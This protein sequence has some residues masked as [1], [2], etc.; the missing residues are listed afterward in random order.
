MFGALATSIVNDIWAEPFGALPGCA[1]G[2]S[3]RSR[4]PYS[5]CS[6]NGSSR[7]GRSL[8]SLSNSAEGQRRSICARHSRGHSATRT[9]SSPTGCR[10]AVCFLSRGQLLKLS[11]ALCNDA[12]ARHVRFRTLVEECADGGGECTA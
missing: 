11:E 9:F 5:P 7:A 4:S 3:R 2:S 12:H 10:P 6:C 1:R 8:V